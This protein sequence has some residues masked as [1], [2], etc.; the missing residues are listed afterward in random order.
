M[1][2]ALKAA[3]EEISL[4]D[5]CWYHIL[6]SFESLEL[7]AWANLM[8]VNKQLA[9]LVINS[10]MDR[11]QLNREQAEAFARSVL[12]HQST[13]L[14]GS[15]GTGKTYVSRKIV[16]ALKAQFTDP[17][18]V[19]VTAS[20][21]AAA[22]QIGGITLHRFAGLSSKDSTHVD[23]G[24]GVDGVPQSSV[25]DQE[26]DAEGVP[27]SSVEVQDQ[28]FGVKL[29]GAKEAAIRAA[30]VLVV[31][32][33]SMLSALTTD[34]VDS[35]LRGA[36]TSA[37]PWGGLQLVIIGDFCQLPPVISEKEATKTS[38]IYAF[39]SKVWK[40]AKPKVV[41]LTTIVRQD[42][43]Q[44]QFISLLQR[45][46]FGNATWSDFNFLKDNSRKDS[47]E[48]PLAL[49]AFNKEVATRNEHRLQQIPGSPVQLRA[50]DSGDLEAKAGIKAPEVINLKPGCTVMAL[51]NQY[52]R[53]QELVYSNG[54]LGTVERIGVTG[55]GTPYVRAN[56]GNG[57]FRN[58]YPRTYK[59]I[60]DGSVKKRRKIFVRKQLP[61]SL[62]FA[63]THH[64]SQ[65]ATVRRKVD[66]RFMA[67][68]KDPKTGAWLSPTSGRLYTVLSRLTSLAQARFLAN[69][70]GQIGHINGVYC[71]PLVKNFYSHASS[72]PRIGF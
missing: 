55:N 21:G 71:D 11:E 35:A 61:L 69:D 6:N 8:G 29:S 57:K 64:K 42:P 68:G 16:R 33:I 67:G 47:E 65:G 36:R 15:A 62:C 26:F 66:I 28:E 54:S 25:Q 53:D 27:R 19:V 63:M 52:G 23:D 2:R 56:W 14:T 51:C 18:A 50:I 10:I 17:K 22:I 9:R 4:N 43:A 7:L 45:W 58:V 20:T 31:D 32:E 37:R 5:D 24:F 41:E 12:L 34:M 49:F 70:K 39:Q 48:S 40:V 44:T 13:F 46:R 59:I 72:A 3:K 30:R 38:L 1:E 60:K